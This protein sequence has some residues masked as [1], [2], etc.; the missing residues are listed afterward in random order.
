MD[1]KK[2][3]SGSIVIGF[4]GFSG[5]GKTSAIK[6]L[7]EVFASKGYRVATIKKTKKQIQPNR[8]G[9]DTSDFSKAGAQTVVLAANDTTTF[10]MSK[11]I[12]SAKI[13]KF[14]EQIDDFDYIFI[15]GANEKEIRKIRFGEKPLREKTIWT[16]NG[17]FEEL[18][19][20][21]IKERSN[22]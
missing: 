18:I 5:S 11:P 16:F 20:R 15:E 21:I 7:I 14:L 22:V 1:F 8:P 13:I 17:D 12:S 6:K 4:Y 2:Q 19:K 3:T 9:K 10:Y